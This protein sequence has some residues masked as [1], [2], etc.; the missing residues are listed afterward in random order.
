[1][2]VGTSKILGNGKIIK[3]W[4]DRWLE[5]CSLSAVYPQLF[6]LAVNEDSLICDVIIQMD[7]HA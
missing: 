7:I 1:M 6:A 5:D 2:D 3:F 4:T